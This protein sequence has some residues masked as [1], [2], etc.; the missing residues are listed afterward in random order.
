MCVLKSQYRVNGSKETAYE[1][2]DSD[3]PG[4][5]PLGHFAQ[6]IADRNSSLLQWRF[7]DYCRKQLVLCRRCP[8][9]QESGAD[10]EGSGVAPAEGQRLFKAHYY[11]N[12]RWGDVDFAILVLPYIRL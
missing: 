6:L 7:R 1:R 12:H 9:E 4:D 11:D 10:P 5:Y 2:D 8:A 3:S